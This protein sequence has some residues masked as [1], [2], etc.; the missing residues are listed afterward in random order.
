[1][2]RGLFVVAIAVA[3]LA[4][5]TAYALLAQEGV[6]T[7]RLYEQVPAAA[8]EGST[9][10]FAWTQNSRS[11]PKHFDAFLKR[12]GDLRVTLNRKGEAFVGGIDPP[13]VAY[14]QVVRGQSDLRLYDADTLTRP[15][16]PAGVNTPNWEWEPSISGDW[17]LFGRQ[18]PTRQ[19]VILQSLDPATPGSIVLDRGTRFRHAGQVSGDFAVWTR[20]RR[21]PATSSAG[22]SPR[23]PTPSSRSRPRSTSTAQRSRRRGSCTQPEA[24]RSVER[25]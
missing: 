12:S 3:L 21:R 2:R 7:T 1:M 17:L 25:T 4:V 13:M 9:N 10:Y 23:P 18:T 15:A 14:Q 11:K 19:L 20:V 22:R 24:G 8:T 5:P 6:K 16:L